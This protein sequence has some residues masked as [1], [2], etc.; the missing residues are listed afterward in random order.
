[1]DEG[2]G[3]KLIVYSIVLVFKTKESTLRKGYEFACT[4]KWEGE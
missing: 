3:S 4:K 1:M 2:P